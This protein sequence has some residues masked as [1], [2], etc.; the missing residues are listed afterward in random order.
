MGKVVT[1]QGLT[2]FVQSG[3]V[4]HVPDH[5]PKTNG[6]ASAPALE[7]KQDDKTADL[8]EKPPEKAAD[9]Q[10][11]KP[12]E[13]KE[14]KEEGLDPEDVDFPERVRQKIGKKHRAMKE[15]Q[16]LAEENERF[17]ENQYNRARLAEERGAALE[18]ELTEAKAKL[19]PAAKEPEAK[20]PVID[21]YKSADGTVDW[22]KFQKDTAKFAANQAVAEERARQ[23]A[24]RAQTESAQIQARIKASVD[25]ARAAH[26]DFNEVMKGHDEPLP[27]HVL[28]YLAES[29]Q[30]G[31]LGYY[32]AKNP[33][34][35][36]RINAL[37]P[38]LA[39]AELGKLEAKLTKPA[40]PKAQVPAAAAPART[41]PAPITPLESSSATVVTD[42][43]KMSFKQL[44]EYERSRRNKRH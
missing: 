44:R 12:E 8:G 31:E 1:S 22:V 5:K 9:P 2:E 30:T 35:L 27:Q 32:L 34:D 42:P 21:D 19:T 14:A 7:V 15:A 26:S 17:A 38:I 13:S 29:E 18:R 25:A 39:I 23:A 37:K 20:E 4:T 10:A 6:D 41:A 3:K 16:E 40:E 43:A 28:N 24:E 33:D 36:K 11:Q